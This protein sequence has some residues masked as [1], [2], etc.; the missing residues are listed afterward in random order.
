MYKTKALFIGC[1]DAQ[2]LLP[3]ADQQEQLLI[4]LEPTDEL[5]A[6][7]CDNLKD[8]KNVLLIKQRIQDWEAA[9]YLGDID[10]IFLSFPLLLFCAVKPR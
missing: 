7:A 9:E 3:L 8:F 6:R 1:G 2:E 10:Q 5:F 4:G